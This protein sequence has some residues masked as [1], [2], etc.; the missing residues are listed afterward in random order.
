[1]KNIYN[2]FYATEI[3][4]ILT[5]ILYMFGPVEYIKSNQV[6][7]YTILVIYNISFILGFNFYIK[8]CRTLSEKEI[9]SFFR[10]TNQKKIKKIF[11]FIIIVGTFSS[12]LSITTYISLSSFSLSSI[13]NKFIYSFENSFIVYKDSF[14]IDILSKGYKPKLITFLGPIAWSSLVLGF[15]CF[16]DL[17]IVY[18]IIVILNYF[19][20]CFRWI[21]TGRNKGV[22]DLFVIFII[23]IYVKNCDKITIKINSF[24]SNKKLI[25][26]ILLIFCF[27]TIMSLYFNNAIGSRVNIENVVNFNNKSIILQIFPKSMH[28]YLYFLTN[29]LTQGYQSLSYLIDLQWTPMFGV[30]NSYFLISK[31]SNFLN[32]DIYSYTYQNKL[33]ITYGIDKY[34]N[35]HSA[36]VWFAND[37]HWIGVILVM[38]IIGY[39][40]AKSLVNFFVYKY[41]DNLILVCLFTIMIMYLSGN[42]QILSQPNTFIT[43]YIYLFFNLLRK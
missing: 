24:F 1:M 15:Y 22:F 32:E 38:F 14:I 21:S 43:F 35:W 33:Q 30:G 8:K 27:F 7:L 36:Y 3:V 10:I 18:K 16:K 23:I 9:P 5:F 13:I 34:V 12:I 11:K 20:E 41:I 4:F 26:F 28:S 6:F 2:I 42:N 19:F 37:F 31:M 29:Y 40:Y 17:N 39:L 25:I